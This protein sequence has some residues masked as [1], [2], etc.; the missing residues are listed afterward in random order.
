M[1]GSTLNM[2]HPN[3]ISS[4]INA[5]SQL[6]KHHQDLTVHS[7]TE[8]KMQTELFNG[9]KQSP[10]EFFQWDRAFVVKCEMQHKNL[11]AFTSLCCPVRFVILR[12]LN[13]IND[14]CLQWG[15]GVFDSWQRQEFFHPNCRRYDALTTILW[16]ILSLKRS[17]WG[18]TLQ[19]VSRLTFFLFLNA[20]RT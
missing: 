9:N 1:M 12:F 18:F 20:C 4:A 10:T 13:I 14:L 8:Y 2:E 5:W 3:D 15:A 19:W 6:V 16:Y 11:S 7:G 17:R